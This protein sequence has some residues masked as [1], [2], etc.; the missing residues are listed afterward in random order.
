MS[1]MVAMTGPT[2]SPTDFSITLVERPVHISRAQDEKMFGKPFSH[3]FVVLKDAKDRVIGEIHGSWK[4]GSS[5]ETKLAQAFDKISG[6]ICSSRLNAFMASA[7]AGYYPQCY[8]AGADGERQYASRLE[9]HLLYK[10]REGT[11]REIW[12][13]LVEGFPAV[14]EKGQ[15]YYRYAKPDD[16]F[17]NCQTIIRGSLCTVE[18]VLSVAVPDL[19][20]A[21]TGW[22][23]MPKMDINFTL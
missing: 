14:N 20:L 21:Q 6:K 22:T 3:P 11:A 15:P 19:K 7:S 5:V 18:N 16:R 12:A 10:G 13:R 9:E 8:I 17:G 23:D 4:R 1:I 2:V